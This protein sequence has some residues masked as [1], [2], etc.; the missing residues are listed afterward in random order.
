MAKNLSEKKIITLD[1]KPNLIAIALTLQAAEDLFAE[2]LAIL[3]RVTRELK[4][5]LA[6][7]D[8]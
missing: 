6:D 5:H 1:N 4:Q 8:K 2:G 3:E 7:E